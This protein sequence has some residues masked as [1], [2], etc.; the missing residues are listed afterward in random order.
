MGVQ[1]SIVSPIV[2]EDRAWGFILVAT[3]TTDLPANAAQQMADFSELLATAIRNAENQAELKASRARIVAA[4]DETRRRI[5][6]NLHRAG[7]RI[8]VAIP[9]VEISGGTD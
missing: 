3:R 1:S 5:E 7:T 4:A 8:D 9:I 6:R 2:I